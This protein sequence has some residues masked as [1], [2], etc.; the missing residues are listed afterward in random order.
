MGYPDE[1]PS[2]PPRGDLEEFIHYERFK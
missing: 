2:P 1:N